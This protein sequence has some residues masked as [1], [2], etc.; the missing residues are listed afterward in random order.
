MLID[1]AINDL[2]EMAG[3]STPSPRPSLPMAVQVVSAKLADL[4][5]QVRD[6]EAEIQDMHDMMAVDDD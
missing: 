3:E 5:A 4:R 1:R 6:L 2:Y